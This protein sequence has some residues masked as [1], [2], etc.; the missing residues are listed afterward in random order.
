MRR[1][2]YVFFLAVIPWFSI[3]CEKESFKVDDGGV[4]LEFSTDTLTFDTVFTTVGTTTRIVTIYNRS[5][6]NLKLSTVTLSGG[7][8]SHFRMNVDGDTS[9]VAH[10]IEIEAG[11]SIFIFVQANINPTDATM[12]FVVEDAIVFS[13]GQRVALTAWGRNAIYH[14]ILP[15]DSTW[16]TVIDCENWNHTLPHVF[17]DPAAVLDGHT[18]TLRNGDELYFYDDAMLIIDSNAHLRVQGTEDAPVLF[19]SMRHDGWYDYLP[20]QWQTIWFYNYSIGNVID[21]A[22]IEN[23][24]CGLR[25]YPGSQLTVSNTVIRNM[26][27]CGIVGQA[28]TITGRNLL[29]YDCLADVT[30]L[31]GGSY[32]FRNCTFANYWSYT[33]RQIECIVLSNNEIRGEEVLGGDLLKADFRDCIIWG[34]YQKEFLLSELEGFTMNYNLNLHSIVKGGEWSE[35]PLFTDPRE[36]DYTLQE[37]SPAIGIGYQFEN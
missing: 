19:T 23:G 16:F 37:E 31:R 20:G 30:V 18:L 3:S 11:D 13:N 9:L 4:K 28:A 5:S 8:A 25:C 21:H 2:V 7:V 14:R 29:V 34:T 32:D 33:A 26:S 35:D 1:L 22:V 24:T 6:D 17:I 27:D 10:D 12:P 15:S 36:D